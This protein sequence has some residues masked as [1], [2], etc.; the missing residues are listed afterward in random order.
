VRA[1][2]V[3]DTERANNELTR[4]DGSHLA[5]DLHDDAAIFVA[6]VHRRGHLVESAIGPE[7][8]AADA[9]RR[10]LDDGVGRKLDFGLGDF[11]AADVAGAVKDS[12]EHGNSLGFAV[13]RR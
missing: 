6:H 1:G 12:G 5:A 9:G 13:G 7:V 11:L 10:Q 2:V 3:G 8:G 4:P